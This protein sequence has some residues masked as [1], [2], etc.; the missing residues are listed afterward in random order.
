MVIGLLDL[1]NIK[2]TECII[3]WAKVFKL[4]INDT[5]N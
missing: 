3:N 1:R 4:N 5:L 2:V